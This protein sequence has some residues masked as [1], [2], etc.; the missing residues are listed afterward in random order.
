M[1]LLGGSGSDFD[2]DTDLVGLVIP[3]L[4]PETKQRLR[5]LMDQARSEDPLELDRRI[6]GGRHVGEARRKLWESCRGP[7][8]ADGL[9]TSPGELLKRFRYLELDSLTYDSLDKDRAVEWCG[10]A[11]MESDD[12]RKLWASLLAEVQTVRP[13]GG[14]INRNRLVKRLESEYAF[15][16]HGQPDSGEQPV[17][18]EHAELRCRGLQIITDYRFRVRDSLADGISRFVDVIAT[19]DEGREMSPSAISHRV[20]RRTVFA[21]VGPSGYGKSFLAQY[22]AVR[23]CEDGRLVVWIHADEYKKGRFKDLLGRSMEPFSSEEWKSLLGAAGEFNVGITFV[24]DGLNECPPSDRGRLVQEL[25]GFALGHSASVLI[26][27]TTDDFPD[28]LKAT[29]LR[30]KAPDQQARLAILTAHGAKHPDRISSQFCTPYE[31]AIAAKCE[32]EL[33][34]NASVT[35]LEAAYIREFAPTEQLR[36]GLR[37]LASHLHSKLRTSMGKQEATSILTYPRGSLSP[38]RVDEVLDCQLL[39]NDRYRVRFRHELIGRYLAAENTVLSTDSGQSLGELL[40]LAPNRVLQE[41]ALRIESDPHRVWEALKVLTRSNLV[42]SALNG[43][44]GADA[45]AMAA[46]EVRD[47]L[48]RGIV[49]TTTGAATIKV[50]EEFFGWWVSNSEWTGWERVLLTAAGRGLPKGIFIEEVCELIDRTDEVCLTQVGELKAEGDRTPISRVVYA[51]YGHT[52]YPDGRG[53]AASYVVTGLK[54]FPMG[55]LELAP[56][57][58]KT[59]V[60][61]RNGQLAARLVSGAGA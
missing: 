45:A 30:V 7:E 40:Q 19:C 32:S 50:G 11:L 31:L 41:T 8:G 48:Q 58:T 52:L 23:D 20:A 1:E 43:A 33:G 15:R 34:E 18:E 37:S 57:G 51:T 47:V 4:H 55:A 16:P 60:Q 3:H 17:D 35:E 38:R 9:S 59:T 24:V 42:F 56:L 2:P 36:A 54:L 13:T 27:S 25:D 39:N 14:Y 26:T 46:H 21:L 61:R 49:C 44:Y 10:N 12:G 53:L 6:G 22:L 29:V 5:S 28:S